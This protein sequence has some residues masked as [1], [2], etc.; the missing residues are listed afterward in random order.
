MPSISPEAMKPH[1]R[2][3]IAF[4]ITPF[5]TDGEVDLDAVRAN[6]DFLATSRV[7]SIVA[8]SGTG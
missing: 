4:P 3:A 8:P 7:A 5:T 1:L 2:G 6:A